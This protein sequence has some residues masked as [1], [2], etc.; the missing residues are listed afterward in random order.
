MVDLKQTQL[1]HTQK[2]MNMHV[3]DL[4]FYIKKLDLEIKLS[5]NLS[6]VNFNVK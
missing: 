5:H 3:C 6:P 1:C 2:Q 4:L